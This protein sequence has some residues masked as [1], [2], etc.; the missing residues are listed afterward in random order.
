MNAYVFADTENKFVSTGFAEEISK[1]AGGERM[2]MQPN[3]HQ[4]TDCD[5]Q[6]HAQQHATDTAVAA[7]TATAAAGSRVQ[8]LLQS[9]FLCYDSCPV[10]WQPSAV[11]CGGTPAQRGMVLA[12]N[13]QLN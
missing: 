3:Y 4:S 6:P 8:I 10:V 13:Q 9:Y 11:C 5:K 7:H 2:Q 12:N 1:A